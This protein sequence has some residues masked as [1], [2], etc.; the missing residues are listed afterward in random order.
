[1]AIKK[2]AESDVDTIIPLETIRGLAENRDIARRFQRTAKALQAA[3]AEALTEVGGKIVEGKKVAPKVEDFTY[4]HCIMMH[5]A[6][7][8]L[9]DQETGETLRNKEGKPVQGTF[10]ELT[11]SRGNKTVKWSSPDGIQMYKNQNGDIFPEEDLIAKHK[12][13]IGKPLCRDHVSSTVDGIRGIVVDTYY[14]PK[15][16]RVHALFALDRKNYPDLAG[17]VERGYATSVSMGTAVGRAICTECANVATVEAEYCHHIR[18]RS[19]YGEINKDLS[20]IELSIVVTGA[21]PRAKIKTVLAH[22]HSY[23]E[24]KEQE[25]RKVASAGGT[26]NSDLQQI[27]EGLRR[28]ESNLKMV[29]AEAGSSLEENLKLLEA[30]EAGDPNVRSIASHLPA[31]KDELRSVQNEGLLRRFVHQAKRHDLPLYQDASDVLVEMRQGG[32]TTVNPPSPELLIEKPEGEVQSTYTASDAMNPGQE[33]TVG[34]ADTNGYSLNLEYPDD[35]NTGDMLPTDV[36][37]TPYEGMQ[38]FSSLYRNI[39]RTGG[40][41]EVASLEKRLANMKDQVQSIENTLHTKEK[42]M[43]FAELKERSLRRREAYWQGTDEPTPGKPQYALMGDQ[44]KIRNTQDKQMVGDE[45]NYGDAQNVLPSEDRPVKEHMQRASLEDRRLRRA[46]WLEEIQK[47]AQGSKVVYDETG[48]P[49]GVK[50]PDGKLSPVSQAAA[51]CDPKDKDEKKD[52][53]KDKMDK[54]RA[55]KEKKAYWQGTEEPSPGQQQYALMGDQDKIRNTLDKQMSGEGME[56]GADGMHP[57]YK[58][59]SDEKVKRYWQRMADLKGRLIKGAKDE[60]RWD[61]FVDGERALSVKANDVYGE[62]WERN[63]P[64]DPKM[65]HAQYFQSEDYGYRL[66][67][68][69]REAQGPEGA[70]QALELPPAGG[71]AGAG[72]PAEGESDQDRVLAKIHEAQDALADAESALDKVNDVEGV[73]APLGAPEAGPPAG[74]AMASS[75]LTQVKTAVESSIAEL[76]VLAEELSG[77]NQM[78]TQVVDEALSD[79][80]EVLAYYKGLVSKVAAKKKDDE[81]EEKDEKKKKKSELLDDLLRVR[82][83]RR[84]ALAAE[85]MKKV[86][87][88]WEGPTLEMDNPEEDMKKR[89]DDELSDSDL[90]RLLEEEPAEP[91]YEMSVSDK[92]DKD[93]DEKE[94]EK[95]D[96]ALDAMYAKDKDED[97]KDDKE[98]EKEDDALDAM[99]AKDKKED[100]EDEEKG[101]KK[102]DESD[103]S[104]M[105]PGFNESHEEGAVEGAAADGMAAKDGEDEKDEKDEKD[106]DEDS[107]KEAR[108]KW[109]EGLV[110][111]AKG[112]QYEPLYEETRTDAGTKVSFDANV[113][114]DLDL[115]ENLH[116][117]HDKHMDVATSEPRNVRMAAELLNNAIVKGALKAEKLDEMVA[118]GMADSEAVKYWKEFYGQGDSESGQF[119]AE[120]AKE[121]EAF[122]QKKASVDESEVREVR[123]RRAYDLGLEAQSKGIIAKSSADLHRYVD[124]VVNLPDQAFESM[125]NIVAQFNKV[126]TAAPQMGLNYDNI[127]ES[128]ATPVKTASA[129]SAT[130]SFEDLSQLF[131]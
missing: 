60:S 124:S 72:A 110:A 131:E 127:H 19:N 26:N 106:E 111:K 18:S 75:E 113:S 32:E 37:P 119:G 100:D 102:D 43:N 123:L 12:D 117:K 17:K 29:R 85:A 91:A 16:K 57:G 103:A 79:T 88:E 27:I 49:V 2:I 82:A 45:L 8:S 108:R 21:D 34:L 56:S 10:E 116:V 109:R 11:D 69:V 74:P 120:M 86:A 87:N 22:L 30:M 61:V 76:K 35:L 126:T 128:G 107:K 39:Q 1:M 33:H 130:P 65:T 54:L 129:R 80:S 4:A 78:V 112:G 20:P 92:G 59:N 23:V 77:G 66:L 125:K 121:F 5:A 48:N 6:E 53:M 101:D 13:W 114:N 40:P 9:I 96:D 71:D 24:K 52:N 28:I 62:V 7:A 94:D 93:E 122:K 68:L 47:A 118:L 14:D 41:E 97:E 70:A 64:E 50:S 84:A 31:S 46:A 104:D 95:E 105:G 63:L 83:E 25:L 3:Q 58:G 42:P 55:K 98:D 36:R 81:D 67:D 89:F 44:D 51:D 73:E 38:G 90:E 15:F 99:Y 115:V